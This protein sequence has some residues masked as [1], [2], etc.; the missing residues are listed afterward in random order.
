LSQSAK[1]TFINYKKILTAE[2]RQFIISKWTVLNSITHPVSVNT[3]SIYAAILVTSTHYVSKHSLTCKYA[4]IAHW[5]RSLNVLASQ[6]LNLNSPAFYSFCC[7]ALDLTGFTHLHKQPQ[8][9]SVNLGTKCICT[10]YQTILVCGTSSRA[11][12]CNVHCSNSRPFSS[13]S[14]WWSEF[15][16]APSRL[17]ATCVL[18]TFVCLFVAILRENSSSYYYSKKLQG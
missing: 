12:V 4:Y 1:S 3:S 7:Y 9:L 17:L 15:D 5:S 11:I 2:R 6:P 14:Y 8:K 18:V 13:L 10:L 16:V